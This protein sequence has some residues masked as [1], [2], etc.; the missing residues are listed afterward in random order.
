MRDE[1]KDAVL[2]AFLMVLLAKIRFNTRARITQYGYGSEVG[3][4]QSRNSSSSK[5]IMF[6]SLEVVDSTTEGLAF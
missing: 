2:E 1:V 5:L 3:Y 4:D 6:K